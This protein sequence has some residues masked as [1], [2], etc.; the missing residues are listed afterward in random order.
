[1][2]YGSKHYVHEHKGRTFLILHLSDGWH[3][4]EDGPGNDRQ[5][6]Y[7]RKRDAITA[8]TAWAAISEKLS[9]E[10]LEKFRENVKKVR[11]AI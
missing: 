4:L 1:M 11:T 9:A 7:E 6:P 2:A 8:A 3:W 5:G 10:E